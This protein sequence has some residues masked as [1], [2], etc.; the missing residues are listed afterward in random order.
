MKEILLTQE[1]VAL[2]DD[3]DF[4]WLNRYSWQASWSK[5]TKCFIVTRRN[6]NNN[7]IT[8]I[9]RF[10]MNC[11]EDMMV[12]HKDHNTLNNQKQNLRICTSQENNRNRRK[13]SH[14]TSK[15][16]GV[17]WMKHRAKWKARIQIVDF[18]DQKFNR[19]LGSFN[20]EKEAALAYDKAASKEFGEFAYLNF[21]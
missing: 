16:K 7:R 17:Y 18:L 8:N 13:R 2:V 4:E 15:Y 10:I 19:T 6:K 9:A 21:P 14:C 3:E 20:T 11:P 5:C 12:D 1:Q